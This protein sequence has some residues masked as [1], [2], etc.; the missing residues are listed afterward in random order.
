VRRE[1]RGLRARGDRG[2]WRSW[3]GAARR[4]AGSPA[5]ARPLLVE[6][7][8][9][10][11]GELV[12]VELAGMGKLDDSDRDKLYNGNCLR[13][14]QPQSGT[15]LFE[16]FVHRVDLVGAKERRAGTSGVDCFAQLEV[17]CAA[18]P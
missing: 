2:P 10:N 17:P 1:V 5:F 7:S 4:R 9:D 18:R 11:V 3:T 16:G 13:P 6:L 15:G 12:R 14:G 8:Q